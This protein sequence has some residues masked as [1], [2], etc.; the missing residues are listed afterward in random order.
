MQ[1]HDV[2]WRPQFIEKLTSKHNVRTTE[3]EEVLTNRPR[4][5]RVSR[6][7]Q[8]GEDVYSAAGQTEAERY[9]IVFFILKLDR[10]ALVISARDISR[11]ERRNYEQRK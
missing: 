5:R 1:I 10:R 11:R 3:V 8:D 9:L 7:H 2:I 4:L 6:G